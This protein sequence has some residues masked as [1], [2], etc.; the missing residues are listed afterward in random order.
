MCA[1]VCACACVCVRVSACE[2]VCVRGHTVI[3][4]WNFSVSKMPERK[5]LIFSFVNNVN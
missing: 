1:C 5:N 2:C 3:S 4:E